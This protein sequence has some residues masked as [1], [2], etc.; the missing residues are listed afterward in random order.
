MMNKGTPCKVTLVFL[1]PRYSVCNLTDFVVNILPARAFAESLVANRMSHIALLR[2]AST[3][4]SI[5]RLFRASSMQSLFTP[6]GLLVFTSIVKR[7]IVLMFTASR[8]DDIS[9]NSFPEINSSNLSLRL[10][11]WSG[12][13]GGGGLFPAYAD[14]LAA[15]GIDSISWDSAI[16]LAFPRHCSKKFKPNNRQE[17]TKR[18]HNKYTKI[19]Y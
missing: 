18:N 7:E 12:P 16:M 8:S 1:V 10:L 13:F 5:L 17:F 4:A 15:V 11:L 14:G 2:R 6:I 3:L 9:K 19:Q